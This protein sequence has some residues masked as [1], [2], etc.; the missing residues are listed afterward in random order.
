MYV[1]NKLADIL[2]DLTSLLTT[3]VYMLSRGKNTFYLKEI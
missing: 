1:F 3:L 2:T